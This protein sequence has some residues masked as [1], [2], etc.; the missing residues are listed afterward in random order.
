MTLRVVVVDDERPA[1]EK[2]RRFLG[3]VPDVEVVAEAA[4]GIGAVAAIRDEAPDLVFLDVQMPGLNGIEVVEA[5]GVDEMPAVV[6]VTAFD[7]YAMAAFEVEAADYLLKPFDEARFR[8][9]LERVRRR[10][11]QD[12][13]SASPSHLE[14][15][16]AKAGPTRGYVQRLVSAERG[17]VRLVAVREVYRFSAE[18]NYARVFTVDRQCLVRRSLTQLEERLDPGRFARIHRSDIVAID[19]IKEL[20]PLSHGDYEVVLK[21]GERVRLSR[22]YHHRLLRSGDTV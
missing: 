20:L 21:N 13:R 12:A 19:A 14:R 2:I 7:R 6:F 5:I 10:L 4:T 3:A 22:R 11:G 9:A 17:R 8:K 18:G 15:V 16:L 1:R